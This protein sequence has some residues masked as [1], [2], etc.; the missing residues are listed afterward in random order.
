MDINQWL[1]LYIYIFMK[2]SDLLNF[3]SGFYICVAGEKRWATQYLFVVKH[4]WEPFGILRT[5]FYYVA[6]TGFELRDQPASA[7]PSEYFPWEY[8]SNYQIDRTWE[9]IVLATRGSLC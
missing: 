6:L 7:F 5:R 2:K 1:W 3:E 8:F 4:F 9:K